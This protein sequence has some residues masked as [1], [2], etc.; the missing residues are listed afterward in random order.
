MLAHVEYACGMWK[1]M[2]SK[3]TTLGVGSEPAW[4]DFGFGTYGEKE[5]GGGV[6]RAPRN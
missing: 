5:T 6:K 4:K 1:G 2:V 3:G